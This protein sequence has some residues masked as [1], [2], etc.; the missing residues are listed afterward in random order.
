MLKDYL[1]KKG[2]GYYLSAV[3]AVF[4]LFAMIMCAVRGGDVLT[5]FQPTVV[6][7]LAIGLV[8]NILILI[9]K[10]T[11]FEIL[12]FI[13]YFVGFAIF[14]GAEV[15][16]IANIIYGVDG[17]SLDA[18]LVTVLLFSLLA[19]I[20]GIISCFKKYDKEEE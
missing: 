9:K 14:V 7:M 11:P 6:L 10:V 18:L 12:P 8:I 3:S 13:C 19:F 15:D 17:N 20:F 4:A 16:F 1:A 5:D 2:S